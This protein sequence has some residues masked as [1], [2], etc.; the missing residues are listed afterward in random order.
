MEHPTKS[1]RKIE[2]HI[3]VSGWK[4]LGT[5][6]ILESLI[7]GVIS[8]IVKWEVQSWKENILKAQKD[9]NYNWDEIRNGKWKQIP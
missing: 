7:N 9:E 3:P 5:K 2:F 6:P 8:K 4:L 1:T